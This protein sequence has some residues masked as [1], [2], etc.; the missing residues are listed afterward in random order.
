MDQELHD[1]IGQLVRQC[2]WIQEARIEVC[3]TSSNLA[4][5]CEAKLVISERSWANNSLITE[6]MIW[7]PKSPRMCFSPSN[8]S[9]PRR[10]MTASIV[11]DELSRYVLEQQE[12]LQAI[13]QRAANIV[14]CSLSHQLLPKSQQTKPEEVRIC[15]TSLHTK[16]NWHWNSGHTVPL[17]HN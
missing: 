11:C 16:K 5:H 7:F 15:W 3:K 12:D 17:P 10:L 4:W 13:L 9:H 2:C 8:V 6:P 14:Q 1:S